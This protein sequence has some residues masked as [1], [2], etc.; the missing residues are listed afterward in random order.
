LSFIF[1]FFFFGIPSLQ[2]MCVPYTFTQNSKSITKNKLIFHLS[3]PSTLIHL[4]SI[5]PDSLR[6]SSLGIYIDYLH[7]L[8]ITQHGVI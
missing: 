8:R 4:I 6:L 5:V 1:N 7:F 3:W 2:L